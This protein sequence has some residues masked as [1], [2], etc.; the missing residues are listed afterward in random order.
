MGVGKDDKTA[1]RLS[2]FR[3]ALTTV[4]NGNSDSSSLPNRLV[5]T[6]RFF[7]V[8]VV[9]CATLLSSFDGE[10]SL[11]SHFFPAHR[12]AALSRN[13]RYRIDLTGLLLGISVYLG[14]GSACHM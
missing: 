14:Q 12:T 4:G 13:P 7:T 3:L 5:W 9:S 2:F 6:I 11:R 10:L 8:H 1:T